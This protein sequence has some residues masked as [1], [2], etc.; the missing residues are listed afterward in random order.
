MDT[1]KPVCFWISVEDAQPPLIEETPETNGFFMLEKIN[2]RGGNTTRVVHVNWFGSIPIS[3]TRW[4]RLPCKVGHR[5]GIRADYK[6]PD[7]SAPHGTLVLKSNGDADTTS[8]VTVVEKL[9]HEGFTV[10]AT[11]Y[12]GSG[13]VWLEIPMKG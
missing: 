2:S 3:S 13:E 5:S 11:D 9:R 7:E 8:L 6:E 4:A 12:R 10:H 1:N